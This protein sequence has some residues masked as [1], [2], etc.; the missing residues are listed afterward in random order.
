MATTEQQKPLDTTP[1]TPLEKE[2]TGRMETVK[3]KIFET[4]LWVKGYAFSL[5]APQG[6]GFSSIV[7]SACERV[8]HKDLA[9]AVI[10]K[11]QTPDNLPKFF[12]KL[13][14]KREV[15]PVHALPP[16]I[17]PGET[18]YVKESALKDR[19]KKNNTTAPEAQP[20][21]W[22]KV[23]HADKFTEKYT[24]GQHDY[25]VQDI[26]EP[27]LLELKY[28]YSARENRFGVYTE[29]IQK[30]FGVQQKD[31]TITTISD[32]NNLPVGQVICYNKKGID[33]VLKGKYAKSDLFVIKKE[34]TPEQA[35]TSVW[36]KWRNGKYNRRSHP[37]FMKS[38]DGRG[39]T[40]CSATTRMVAANL[41]TVLPRW[42]AHNLINPKPTSPDYLGKIG[43]PVRVWWREWGK[44][45]KRKELKYEDFTKEVSN[46]P[47]AKYVEVF[48]HAFWSPQYRH[49]ALGYRDEKTGKWYV[50]DPYTYPQERHIPM[51]EYFAG[52]NW[53][54]RQILRMNFYQSEYPAVKGTK[55]PLE[56]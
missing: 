10:N 47:A 42:D 38:R 9:Y 13:V 24:L 43:T 33:D 37:V 20:V 27:V 39:A 34:F 25:L 45:E 8:G 22:V 3:D 30:C 53:K 35:A 36:V 44:I 16:N 28:D 1:N 26:L 41:E 7:R 18:Y 21:P 54:R 56:V 2:K 11:I 48:S 52:K 17:N 49:R 50:I 14:G 6:G 23:E 5:S 32:I 4:E 31:G 51:E 46:Y 29:L 19:L 55:A 15:Q 40:L 12:W